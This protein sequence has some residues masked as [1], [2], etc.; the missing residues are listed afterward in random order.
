MCN[1]GEKIQ[2]GANLGQPALSLEPLD[3]SGTYVLELSSY[4]L[5]LIETAVFNVAVW[6][7]L[8]ADHLDRHGGIKGYIDAKKNIFKR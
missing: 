2:I 4:Q 1:A 8:S 7:N 6:L 5:D 3:G